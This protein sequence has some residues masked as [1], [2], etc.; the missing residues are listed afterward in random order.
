MLDQMQESM[1]PNVVEPLSFPEPLQFGHITLSNDF[2]GFIEAIEYAIYAHIELDRTTTTMSA[3]ELLAT[4]KGEL[5]GDD[6]IVPRYWRVGSLVGEII[7][8]L[9]PTLNT[10]NPSHTYLESLSCMFQGEYRR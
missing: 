1:G 7:G 9:Y 8:F 3:R 6:E 10:D 4:L 2:Q 5:D